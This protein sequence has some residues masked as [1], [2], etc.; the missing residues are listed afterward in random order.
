MT[1]SN[2]HMC[3]AKER[4]RTGIALLLFM[5]I[6]GVYTQTWVRSVTPAPSALSVS[7]S[8]VITAV[9]DRAV[10]P[11][12][13][14]SGTIRVCGSQSGWHTGVASYN[15][16]TK[17]VIFDPDMDFSLGEKIIVTLTTGIQNSMG[18]PLP[19]ANSWEFCVI[20]NGTALF[21]PPT[22]YPTGIAPYALVAIDIENDG[23]LDLA[24][25]NAGANT[26]SILRNQGNGRFVLASSVNAGTSPQAIV[27]GD[28]NFDGSTDLAVANNGSNTISILLNNGY[29]GFVETSTVGAG[30]NPAGLAVGDLDGDGDLDI[31]VA[32]QWSNAVFLLMNDGS[33]KFLSSAPISVG[34]NPNSIIVADLDGDRDL[35]IAVTNYGSGSI[36]V[37]FNNGVGTFS[38]TSSVTVGSNPVA[39]V[40]GDFNRNGDLDLAVAGYG[41]GKIYY[42]KNSGGG[43]F[44][45]QSSMSLPQSPTGLACGDFDGDGDLDLLAVAAQGNQFVVLSNNSSASFTVGLPFT[46]EGGPL[47]P[48]LG[49]FDGDNDLDFVTSNATA[50][51]VSFISNRNTTADISTSTAQLNFNV[52]RSFIAESKNFVIRNESGLSPLQITGINSSSAA[53]SVNPATGYLLP[54]DSLIVK[55]TFTPLFVKNY[56]DSLTVLSNDPGKPYVRILDIG[57]GG[58]TV[59]G[60]SPVRHSLVRTPSTDITVAF[61]SSMTESSFND[62]SFSIFGEFSG[63]VR[64][65]IQ[66]EAGSNS[67]VL[68]PS[69]TLID[70][71]KVHV[72][73][74]SR[75]RSAPPLMAPMAGGY[76]FNFLTMAPSGSGVFQTDTASTI[77]AGASPFGLAAGDFNRDGY[78]DL[79]VANSGESSISV[80]LANRMGGFSAPIAYPVGS[81]P[82]A[83]CVTD[84]DGDGNVDLVT[85][86]SGSNNIS[87]LRGNGAGVFGTG[88]NVTVG[89]SPRAV[90]AADMD[91]DG[92]MDLVVVNA[93]PATLFVYT[94]LITGSGK[95]LSWDQWPRCRPRASTCNV[96][97]SATA[98]W[99]S[100]RARRAPISTS[101]RSRGKS[102]S[103]RADRAEAGQAPDDPGLPLRRHQRTRDRPPEAAGL[104]G[105]PDGRARAQPL[106]R[107]ALPARA[108][109]DLRRLRSRAVREKS[110]DQRSPGAA[111]KRVA[112]LFAPAAALLFAACAGAP[113]A[114]PPGEPG[115]ITPR[116]EGTKPCRRPARRPLRPSRPA[117]PPARS[118]RKPPGIC[119]GPSTP[120]RSSPP[121]GRRRRSRSAGS[122]ICPRASR[123]PPINTSATATPAC[124]RGTSMRRDANSC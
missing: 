114:A 3:G 113:P 38:L 63:R 93:R 57:Q 61:N 87:I 18:D 28:F 5:G 104:P 115:A 30:S 37:L 6:Q 124:R 88:V 4:V 83:V 107:R 55:V 91:A 17:S 73:F 80:F 23:D 50:N 49:D 24:T 43:A 105:G 94:Q 35:D 97:P 121:C 67:I 112:A 122:P 1:A 47:V 77:T 65:T 53:F 75:V 21:F 33:G 27:A 95:T 71:E 102:P 48:A 110:R 101:R 2:G 22:N 116:A 109:D 26:V 32:S 42:L 25:A 120:G 36:S 72:Q 10:N 92:D 13:L 19:G 81:G 100:P 82:Q 78:T 66:Y 46:I 89:A 68:N 7:R 31:V 118:S 106:L 98:T 45:T 64:G 99:R 90:A 8:A 111:V 12:T 85:A 60:S 62:S 56:R 52:V 108:L 74:N 84:V 39:I 58:P 15:A 9:F 40:A 79:V 96:T 14:I 54:L 51:T 69:K 70:G 117:S 44:Q 119:A 20:S 86:N 103:R 16:G 11:A 34:V 59:I 29:G 123:R 41:S 76:T